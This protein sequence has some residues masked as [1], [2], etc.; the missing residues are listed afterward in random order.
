[1]ATRKHAEELAID[2][3]RDPC[4][5]MPVPC[6]KGGKRPRESRERHTAI[7]HWI[8]L[9]IRRVIDSGEAMPDHLRIDP[10]RHYRQTEHDEKIDSLECYSSASASGATGRT[11]RGEL[12]LARA[13]KAIFLRGCGDTP[14]FSLLR[15]PFSHAACE[16]I[17]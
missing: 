12:A 15:R 14:I 17:R 2:H 1:M 16:T 7:H 6:V 5:R 11:R 8:V 3:V 9:D 10:K 13:E 4:E